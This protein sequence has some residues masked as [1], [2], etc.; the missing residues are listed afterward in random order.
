MLTAVL[1]KNLQLFKKPQSLSDYRKKIF[2]GN[3]YFG[4]NAYYRAILYQYANFGSYLNIFNSSVNLRPI[5]T[6]IEIQPTIFGAD[7]RAV[8]SKYGKPVFVLNE[9]KLTIFVYKMKFNGMKT[10]CE[11]H[12]YNNT[13]F[14]INYH[15][16]QLTATEKNCIIKTISD[17]YINQGMDD[18][19]RNSKI[20][21]RNNN[22]LYI[23]DILEGINITYLGNKESVWHRDLI[24]E[25]DARKE[26]QNNKIKLEKKL[27]YNSI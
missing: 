7:T 8:L 18:D 3:N 25:I 24:T 11:I 20:I 10:R 12:F 23:N 15:Y 27:F 22:I 13:V 21:D 14:L 5:D 16:S 6:D 19:I 1:P 17:K 4:R 26:K 2:S 9:S